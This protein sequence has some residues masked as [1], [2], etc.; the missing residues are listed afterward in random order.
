MWKSY[1]VVHFLPSAAS[2]GE[3]EALT[4]LGAEDG[5]GSRLCWRRRGL[6]NYS[7]P[8]FPCRGISTSRFPIHSTL[9]RYWAVNV[10]GILS[11][12]YLLISSVCEKLFLSWILVRTREMVISWIGIDFTWKTYERA[13]W[14]IVAV[15]GFNLLR[16]RLCKNFFRRGL[17]YELIEWLKRLQVCCR[18]TWLNGPDYGP[19]IGIDSCSDICRRLVYT[20]PPLNDYYDSRH[21]FK[22]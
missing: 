19:K 3:G 11:L 14:S 8:A 6:R 16:K 15:W 22:K 4:L 1:H 7:N 12:K 18:N 9:N 2:R 21:I 5:S 20:S 17:A 10:Q 13:G